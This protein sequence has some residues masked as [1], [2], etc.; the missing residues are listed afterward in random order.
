[1]ENIKWRNHKNDFDGKSKKLKDY[2]WI[3]H[4]ISIGVGCECKEKVD[5]VWKYRGKPVLLRQKI[6][7]IIFKKKD[8]HGKTD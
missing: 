5:F 4:H 7:S 8:Y 3:I 2:T 1:L 6:I